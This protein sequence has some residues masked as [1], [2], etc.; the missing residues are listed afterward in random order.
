MPLPPLEEAFTSCVRLVER[1]VSI[2]GCVA[3]TEEDA[4]LRLPSKDK[5]TMKEGTTIFS[6]DL[7]KNQDGTSS[8]PI[9]RRSSR[10]LEVSP[11]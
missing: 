2:N 4:V 11:S 10:S 1:P 5:Q 7:N 3:G 8:Q 9:V 6:L